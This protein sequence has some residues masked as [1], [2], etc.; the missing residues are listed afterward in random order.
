MVFAGIAR[1][2]I[3]ITDHRRGRVI[4]RWFDI[5]VGAADVK[6]HAQGDTRH[7]PTE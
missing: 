6:E 5:H 4:F 3:Q 2:D 1:P 7:E